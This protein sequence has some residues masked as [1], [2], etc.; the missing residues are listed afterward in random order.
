MEKTITK[1]QSVKTIEKFNDLLL[2]RATNMVLMDND[3]RKPIAI[4]APHPVNG[5]CPAIINAIKEDREDFD[6]EVSISSAEE[7]DYGYVLLL[8]IKFD[9]NGDIYNA[10]F[11]A[12]FNCIYTSN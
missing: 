9:D 8:N 3:T 12:H 10:E 6:L 4:I 11:E 2:Q 5:L 7:F 1:K